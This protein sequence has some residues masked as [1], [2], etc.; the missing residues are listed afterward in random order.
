[1]FETKFGQ[2]PMSK[3]EGR[4]YRELVIGKGGSQPEMSYLES[5]LGRAPNGAA[6]AKA[7]RG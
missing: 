4:R 6:F 7:L 2:D 5:F 1:M 3:V